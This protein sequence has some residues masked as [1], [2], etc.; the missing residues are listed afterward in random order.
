MK[1]TIAGGR[2]IDPA[3]GLDQVAH[4]HLAE[5]R[6]AGIGAAPDG[7]RPDETLDATGQMVAPGLVDLRAHLCEPGHEHKG[8]IASESAAAAAG[9]ITTL[10]TAPE[11]DPVTDSAAVAELIRRHAEAAGHA[12][13]LPV[14]AL[15]ADLA[16]EQISEMAAL[17]EAGCIAVGNGKRPVA[18]TLVMRR[19]LEYAASLGLPVL[20]HPQEPWLGR[21]AVHEGAISVRLGL[22]GIPACAEVI[23]MQR[24]LTLVEQTGARV[25]FGQLSTARAADLV[26]DAQ[27]RGLP[28]SADVAAHQLYL[29]EMDV[30]RFNSQCHLRPPLR[31]ERDRA[32]L[33]AAV[34]DGA[35]GAI[36]SDHQPHDRDAKLAPFAATEPGASTLETLLSLTLRL[37]R[38]GTLTLHEALARVTCGPARALGLDSG[39]LAVGA[40][41]DL[42]LFDPELRWT[43]GSDTLRSRGHNTPFWGW[44]M[45]GRTTRTVVGGRLVYNLEAIP[46]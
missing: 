8:T 9:G 39:R 5:G 4:L 2:L 26:R 14:G 36:C 6:I 10:V 16:G 15:T 32:G 37:V 28:V 19:A 42:C 31:S 24:D 44:E 21:G 23:A 27:R 7:F 1:L 43:I 40:P 46:S 3:S 25:H 38:E 33:C 34:A 30:G 13:V 18:D 20:L 35:I 29:T 22:T 45:Q 17:H 12:R 41:A 11:T